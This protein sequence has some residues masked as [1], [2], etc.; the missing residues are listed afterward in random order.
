MRGL[1]WETIPGV[2]LAQAY[3]YGDSL[4]NVLPEVQAV[5]AWK[6]SLVC[7]PHAVRDGQQLLAWID[8]V[9]AFPIA[10][11]RDRKLS[12]YA[13]LGYL[14][15]GGQPLT[16]NKQET[17]A[18]LVRSPKWRKFL[19]SYMRS[20]SHFCPPLY[21]GEAADLPKRVRDHIR[22]ET[23]FGSQVEAA[24]IEWHELELHYCDLGPAEDESDASLA[25]ARRTLLE[26]VL[27]SLSLAAY[28]DR[29]G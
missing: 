1:E 23:G 4:S 26:L 10:E 5:Y 21:V 13:N 19:G 29:S 3:N 17:I 25:K 18:G 12:H 8:D 15:I 22:G 20:L 14:R 9:L 6:R 27:T 24:G 11:L 2:D 7:P 16:P 28:V